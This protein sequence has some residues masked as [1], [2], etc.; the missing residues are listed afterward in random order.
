VLLSAV[1]EQPPVKYNSKLMN[2]IW[3]L[4]NRY[5]VHNLKKVTEGEEAFS[6]SAATVSKIMLGFI[7]LYTIV[8]TLRNIAYHN[9]IEMLCSNSVCMSLLYST[10]KGLW[11]P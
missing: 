1:L 4:Y 9:C 2:S 5:S 11:N 10:F 6:G 8:P 3:G 7:S